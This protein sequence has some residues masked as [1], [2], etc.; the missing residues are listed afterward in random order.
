MTSLTSHDEGV[1]GS[2][3]GGGGGVGVGGVGSIG[4]VVS[5]GGAG[6]IVSGG[7]IGVGGCRVEGCRGAVGGGV[8]GGA[9]SGS[10]VDILRRRLMEQSNSGAPMT[11]TSSASASR[12]AS[13]NSSPGAPISACQRW[14]PS[15]T[16]AAAAKSGGVDSKDETEE[17]SARESLRTREE[18][19]EEQGKKE[20]EE[21]RSSSL[22]PPNSSMN[23]AAK[24]DQW[25]SSDSSHR[26]RKFVQGSAGGGG[27]VGGKSHQSERLTSPP[28]VNDT[29]SDGSQEGST[30]FLLS[31]LYL[32]QSKSSYLVRFM[33]LTNSIKIFVCSFFPLNINH[34]RYI[35]KQGKQFMPIL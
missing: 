32:A 16:V 27:G 5:A 29:Q 19:E 12:H 22:T 33:H 6:L 21:E 2:S 18:E 17:Y 15:Q 14:T 25:L 10:P 23:P 3:A 1:G 31:P 35:L 34:N 13:R 24:Q 28:S 9:G 20:R 4:G 30:Y 8:G 26:R 7:G 11:P